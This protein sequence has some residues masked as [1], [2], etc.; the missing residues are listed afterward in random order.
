[1]EIKRLLFDWLTR[2]HYSNG[3]FHLLNLEIFLDL[4]NS[5]VHNEIHRISLVRTASLALHF[6]FFRSHTTQALLSSSNSYRSLNLNAR[7]MILIEQ[8]AKHQTWYST[9][10][11]FNP[12]LIGIKR[13]DLIRGSIW[14]L[15]SW[16]ADDL[17]NCRLKRIHSVAPCI[18][19]ICLIS[20]AY[21]STR[22]NNYFSYII[23]L[24]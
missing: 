22:M 19:F 10:S 13:R 15:W 20:W 14:K 8:F 23:I 1:M 18:V 9:K 6:Q 24:K 12:K 3:L 2:P 7:A 16:I 4:L 21:K 5:T 11:S 17:N